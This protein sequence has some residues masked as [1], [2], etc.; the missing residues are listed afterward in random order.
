M[1][2]INPWWRERLITTVLSAMMKIISNSDLTLVWDRS[3]ENFP[4]KTA[5]NLKP[6]QYVS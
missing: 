6:W 2:L 1:E 3:W 5:L 4:E